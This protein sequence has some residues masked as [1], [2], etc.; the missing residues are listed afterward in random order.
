MASHEHP[1]SRRDKNDAT[2]SGLRRL[3]FSGGARLL[4]L[5]PAVA[6][7]LLTSA[8]H[9]DASP[10]ASTIVALHAQRVAA[11]FLAGAAL[12]V[13]GVFAQSIASN[14][15]ADPAILGTSGGAFLGA[16]VGLALASLLP[17]TLAARAGASVVGALAGAIAAL[18]LLLATTQRA[19]ALEFL[20]TGFVLS[21]VFSGAST[22]LTAMAQEY[23]SLGRALV[24]LGLGDLSGAGLPEL[25][26]AAPLVVGGTIAALLRHEELDLLALG[27]D[28]AQALGLSVQ[29]ARTSMVG[30]IACTTTAAVILGGQLAFVGLLAPHLARRIVGGAHRRLVPLAAL[31]G[32]VIV[33]AS[34]RVAVALGHLV[35]VP[36]GAIT[37]LAGAPF[38]FA[39]LRTPRAQRLTGS[40]RD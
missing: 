24:M 14:P 39:L 8:A 35:S 40:S 13:A 2:P 16:K 21:A 34:D 31:L 23:P 29:S 27:A 19:N 12:A 7:V 9:A 1:A 26:I 28:E 36:A 11:A 18:A 30:W 33:V 4:V 10:V 17:L 15:L 20:L 37:T 22:L 38:F 3:C 25:R 6:L 32:G 5:L